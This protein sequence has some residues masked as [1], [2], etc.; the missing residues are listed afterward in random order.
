MEQIDFT[1][2]SIGIL[3]VFALTIF[4]FYNAWVHRNRLIAASTLIL[5]GIM[6]YMLWHMPLQAEVVSPLPF[7]W[8]FGQG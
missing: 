7:V 1:S 6:A 8:V 5:L 3:V 4:A 2:W